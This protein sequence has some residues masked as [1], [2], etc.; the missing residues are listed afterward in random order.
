M[1]EQEPFFTETPSSMQMTEAYNWY[2]E[3]KTW[4]DSQRYI[5]QWLTANKKYEEIAKFKLLSQHE[6]SWVCGWICRLQSRGSKIDEQ[7]IVYRD[8]WLSQL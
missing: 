1:A 5:F 2:A 8:V 7:S 4:G 6:I 3:H